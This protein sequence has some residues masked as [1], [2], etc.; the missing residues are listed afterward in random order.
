M[1][2]WPQRIKVGNQMGS[3][4]MKLA[5]YLVPL[6]GLVPVAFGIS[7]ALG[8]SAPDKAQAA[9]EELRVV[10]PAIRETASSRIALMIGNAHYPDANQPLKQSGQRCPGA[11]GTVAAR[12]LRRR[13]AV[14][15]AGKDD[16][17]G[18]VLADLNRR[19]GPGTS[20]LRVLQRVRHSGW[21]AQ[22][23]MIP[24]NAQIWKEADVRR[25]GHLHRNRAS[26]R[27]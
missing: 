22:S 8:K 23:Y 4:M 12:R 27:R 24:V 5:K 25:D 6:V 17:S 13:H 18:A 21:A 14:E 2:R 3:T 9:L 7:F 1:S 16:M 20:A 26:L 15:N 19:S 11:G 10:R